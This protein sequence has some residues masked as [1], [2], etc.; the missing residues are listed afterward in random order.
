[1]LPPL[2]KYVQNLTVSHYLRFSLSCPS[3][4][5]DCLG[6]R[7]NL[8]NTLFT[9]TFVLESLLSRAARVS[10]SKLRTELAPLL[11]EASQGS[12]TLLGLQVTCNNSKHHTWSAIFLCSLWTNH[13][14]FL[15]V[16]QM[17]PPCSGFRAF[18]FI[19]FFSWSTLHLWIP[20]ACPPFQY[21]PWCHH[22]SEPF[23]PGLI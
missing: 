23:F 1:M 18:I 17:H 16:Q 10:H 5:T 6:Y 14:G 2:V 12:S 9:F 4:G 19:I 7:N 20:S 8:L 22:L 11:R 13:T 21:L 15:I 3:P